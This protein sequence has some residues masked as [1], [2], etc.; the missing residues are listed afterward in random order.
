MPKAV[1]I[2]ALAGALLAGLRLGAGFEESDRRRLAKKLRE[3]RRMPERL[4]T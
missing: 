3:L 1:K 4:L 2:L